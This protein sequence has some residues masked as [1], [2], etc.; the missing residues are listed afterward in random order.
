MRLR[1]VSASIS[2]WSSAWPMCRLPVTFGGGSTIEYGGLVAGGV[3]SEV[4]GV[5][6]ALVQLAL[7]RARIPRLG[8]GLPRGV[9]GG[10]RSWRSPGHSR[11]TGDRT[12]GPGG[13][14][15]GPPRRTLRCLRADL[16]LPAEQAAEDVA[17]RRRPGRRPSTL[18]RMLPSGLLPPPPPP[19]PPPRML[20]RMSPRP[21][22]TAAPAAAGGR[23]RRRPR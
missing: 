10:V 2:V 5:D 15:G 8:Q 19:P 11:K 16:L 13:Q 17:E 6:P 9:V 23:R 22:P 4:A 20:P 7:H 21:P 12:Q 1:R 18:P 14:L 3:G